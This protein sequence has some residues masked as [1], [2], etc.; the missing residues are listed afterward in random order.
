[1]RAQ[2]SPLSYYASVVCGVAAVV[3][4]VVAVVYGITALVCGNVAVGCDAVPFITST[5]KVSPALVPGVQC[6]GEGARAS[7]VQC[8]CISVSV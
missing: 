6:G 1:M 3:C 8:Q 4:R 2:L 5:E 7:L